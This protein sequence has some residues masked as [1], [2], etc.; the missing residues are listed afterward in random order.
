M[1]IDREAADRIFRE[2]GCFAEDPRREMD[3]TLPSDVGLRGPY[4]IRRPRLGAPAARSPR[5]C[6][7]GHGDARGLGH[8][9]TLTSAAVA[10]WPRDAI[11]GVKRPLKPEL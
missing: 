5:R 11:D 9:A 3:E 8:G 2:P 6:R 4:G 7:S 10:I 1:S